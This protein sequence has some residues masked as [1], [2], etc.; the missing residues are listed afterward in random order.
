[1][2][3]K[4]VD[5]DA[6]IKMRQVIDDVELLDYEALLAQMAEELPSMEAL[7][8]DC[9]ALY[10]HGKQPTEKEAEAWYFRCWRWTVMKY[11]ACCRDLTPPYSPLD[12]GQGYE[13]VQMWILFHWVP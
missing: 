1:M 5:R 12:P 10:N 13:A 8:T 2:T 11:V 9:R 3:T 7:W 4:D 6:N